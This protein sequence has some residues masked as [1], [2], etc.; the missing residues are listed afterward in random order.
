MA[1]KVTTAPALPVLT[2]DEAKTYLKV[3][4]SQEDTLIGNIVKA[5]RLLAERYLAQAF[6]TQTIEEVFDHWPPDGVLKLAVGPVQ[7]VSSITYVDTDGNSQVWGA[8][9]YVVD[10]HS[11]EARITPAYGQTW[12]SARGQINAITIEYV[13]GY[14][15][16]VTDVPEAIRQ[17][18]LSAVAD[19]YDNREDYVKTLPT[20]SQFMLDHFIYH[21]GV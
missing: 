3:T 5:M 20:A 19:K 14:G 9:N 18:I 17:A 13:A 7:S 16:A 12:P 1:W 6:I 11:I 21:L 2:T 8:S 4:G 10:T 15:A